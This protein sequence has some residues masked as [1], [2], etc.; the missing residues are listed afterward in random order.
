MDCYVAIKVLIAKTS[1]N[2]RENQTLRRLRDAQINY[3]GKSCVSS[4][5]DEFYIDGLN[6]RYLCLV[7]ESARCS[8]AASKGVSTNLMFLMR[9][10][11]AAAAQAILGLDYIHVCGVI[12]GGRRRHG[13]YLSKLM[14]TLR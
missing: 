2:N 14:L 11:W 8:I 1:R 13:N 12:H 4:L 7:S 5:S 3:L 10:A 9:I 6:G